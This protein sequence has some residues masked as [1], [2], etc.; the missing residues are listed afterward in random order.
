MLTPDNNRLDYGQQLQPPQDYEF[1]A[2]IATTY[3]VDLN[4]LLAVPIALC[5]GDTLEGD[6]KGEK[7]ALF[8]AIGRMKDRLKVFYQKGNIQRPATF[9]PLFTLLEPC[10][11]AVIPEGG[12]FSSFH[13]KLWLIRYKLIEGCQQQAKVKYRLLIMSRNLTMDRSWDIAVTL[14]GT[15]GAR[16]NN[17]DGNDDWKT[18]MYSLL[19]STTDFEPASVLK[20]ELRR[21][22]WETPVPFYGEPILTVGSTEFGCPVKLPSR[23]NEQ[24][25]VVSPFIDEHALQWLKTFVSAN[26]HCYL[27]SRADQLNVLG[28]TQLSGWECFSINPTIVNGEERAEIGNTL[29]DL[30]AKIIVS[31]KGSKVC[32]HLGSA[33]ATLAALGSKDKVPRNTEVMLQLSG[34]NSKVGPDM[35]LEEWVNKAKGNGLFVPHEFQALA[36]DEPNIDE[37]RM[38]HL[39]HQL[40]SAEWSLSAQPVAET[41]MYDLHLTVRGIELLPAFAAVSVS[42]LAFDRAQAFAPD[43]HWQGVSLTHISAFIPV[44][45]VIH[46]DGQDDSVER[47]LIEAKLEIQG[48]DTRHQ[49]I[50]RNLV[51][52]EK[53]VLDYIGLLL[54]GTPNKTQWLAFENEHGNTQSMAGAAASL[55]TET[56]IFEQL[57]WASSRNPHLIMRVKQLLTD[58][59]KADVKVPEKFMK[60]WKSF[61]KEVPAK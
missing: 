7:L 15:L 44:S 10:L 33:N 6:L 20:R 34:V 56:P 53:K 5:F 49:Q 60:L 29:H 16:K 25:L 14:D 8:E 42:Q 40:I 59:D 11:Q 38:R 54:Q 50:F 17:D 47:L 9:N 18:F 2:A 24:L 57:L 31:R 52:S 37:T 41:G 12:A 51:G 43:M 22:V 35:L 58:L 30:H 61:E 26:G 48:G 27:F 45:V 28:E 55:F 1:Y 23:T 3:S 21:I 4:T 36:D 32:W 13:P 39:L 19:D 46:T